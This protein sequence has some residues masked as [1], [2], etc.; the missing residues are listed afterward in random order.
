MSCSESGVSDRS[1]NMEVKTRFL[2]VS[3]THSKE[4]IAKGILFPDEPVDVA[5]HCGDLDLTNRSTLAEFTG[6]I[7]VL[8]LINA[9]LKLVIPGNHD[10][11][12]DLDMFGKIYR[13]S[14]A[15][16]NIWSEAYNAAPT[17][18]GY[19]GEARKLF[20]RSK[21]KNVI[22]IGG[23]DGIYRLNRGHHEFV[24]KNGAKLKVYADPYTPSADGEGGF[25]FK[26]AEGHEYAIDPDVDVVITHGPPKGM[27]DTNVTGK[28]VGCAD[29]AA[30][31]ARV[32]PRMHCFGHIHE[33]WGA[34]LVT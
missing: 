8:K 4:W 6:A 26:R 32:R 23:E 24:L 16:P 17:D 2:I 31:V 10:F 12:L 9:P 18:Y 7:E 15:R 30:A 27:L 20:S 13:N 22:C 25:Q 11:T 34:Q 3:D 33:G 19:V 1:S 21:W 29:L 28:Q 14:Q 5:I